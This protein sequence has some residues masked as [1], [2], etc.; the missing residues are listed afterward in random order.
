MSGLSLVGEGDS[1][2]M[3]ISARDVNR[4]IDKSSLLNCCALA[5]D[6]DGTLASDGIVSQTTIAALR[7]L[8][9]ASWRLLLVT[10]RELGELCQLF[11]QADMFER[12]I[13]ENGA[14]LYRPLTLDCRLLAEKPPEHFVEALRT[15][16]VQPIRAG[17]V[18]V[19]TRE[20]QEAKVL[21]V[22][23]ELGLELQIIFNKG[24]V[25]IL[26]TGVNKASGLAAALEELQLGAS[27]VAAIGDAENDHALLHLCGFPAAVANAVPTLKEE[28]VWVSQ[29]PNG[30]GVVE[31][32]EEILL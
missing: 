14:L 28:A 25:M 26:P 13:A 20:P 3:A 22:I 24:A 31:L 27:Q 9:A 8:K 21:E 19:A 4:E 10:G 17:K 6:Y 1:G 29:S 5:C 2:R 11:P 12:I 30:R 18:I 15:R 7:R 16:G 32:I 23:R